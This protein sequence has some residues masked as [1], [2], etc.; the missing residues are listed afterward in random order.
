MDKLEEEEKRAEEV[1]DSN[2]GVHNDLINDLLHGVDEGL[3]TIISRETPRNQEFKSQ[4]PD[5]EEMRR[6]WRQ[7]SMQILQPKSLVAYNKNRVYPLNLRDKKAATNSIKNNSYLSQVEST[8]HL[9]RKLSDKLFQAS[10]AGSVRQ[11]VS[12][13]ETVVPTARRGRAEEEPPHMLK[14]YFQTINPDILLPTEVDTIQFKVS[15][16]RLTQ[17]STINMS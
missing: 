6:Y 17:K 14:H 9:K 15:S 16:A 12:K 2:E 10:V 4:H 7:K 1:D 5:N 11:S 3:S 8:D 13:A